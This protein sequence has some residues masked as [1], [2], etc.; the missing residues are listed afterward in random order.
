MEILL[1][2][3]LHS[4]FSGASSNDRIVCKKVEMPVCPQVGWGVLDETIKEIW[5]DGSRIVFFVEDDN[6][7]YDV[8]KSFNRATKEQMDELEMDYISRGWEKFLR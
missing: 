4:C 5:F 3:R 1:V 6:T 8:K 7:F 2:K